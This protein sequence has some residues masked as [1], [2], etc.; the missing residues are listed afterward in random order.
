[1]PVLFTVTHRTGVSPVF[2]YIPVLS[3]LL[4]T[5]NFLPPRPNPAIVTERCNTSMKLML[6]CNVVINVP[7]FVLYNPM[8]GGF[9][10]HVV[11]STFGGRKGVTSLNTA[12]QFDRDRVPNFKVDFLAT[13]L[14]IVLVTIIAVVRVA[15]T[16]DTTSSNLFCGIVLFLNGSAVTVLVSLL[17]TV[18]AVN[19]KH[20]GAVPSLVSSYK[21]T[22][23]NVTNL[24]LVVNNNNT[25]GRI[26]VSSNI[27]R[28]VSA[29]ISNVSVGPVLVT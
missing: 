10:R 21:G 26:L 17:F 24:L 20:K 4:I 3:N 13:V 1:M 12:H 16:G 5:R 18:C 8:L 9:Y 19:L 22:V 25:F 11:P 2:V 27:N 14:P 28:C 23:T 15:R 7:A 6:V 29:L